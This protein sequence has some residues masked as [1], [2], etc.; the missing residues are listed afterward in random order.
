MTPSAAGGLRQTGLRPKAVDKPVDN[1]GLQVPI[2]WI[3]D[4]ATERTM[5]NLPRQPGAAAASFFARPEPSLMRRVAL[6]GLCL[7]LPSCGGYRYATWRNPPFTT[8][9]QPHAPVGDSENLRRAMGEDVIVKPLTP[10]PGDVWPGPLQPEPTLEDLV[11]QG[12]MGAP[13][14]PVPGSP[15]QR[16][17]RP[18][19]KGSSTPPANAQPGLPPLPAFPGT[20]A[21][22]A[23]PPPGRNPGGQVLQT[24]SGP[25]VT[26]GGTSGYQT[27][28]EPGGG[29]AVVVP[30]GNGTST[31]IHS[32]GRIETVPTPK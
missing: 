5:Y 26:N 31:I 8:G 28:T 21:A 3:S 25:A 17:T 18:P 10:E 6:L 32:D 9:F 22:P 15:L 20:S 13:E 4:G 11:K 24:P 1:L 12:N 14:Q 16:G 30:N 2:E 27:L 7:M 19:I 23:A 29:S